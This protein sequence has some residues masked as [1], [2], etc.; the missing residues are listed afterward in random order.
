MS[1]TAADK[2]E[3]LKKYQRDPKDT[4]SPEAQVALTTLRIN[5]LTE[6][7]KTHKHDNESRRGLMRLVSQRRKLLTYLQR[8]DGKAYRKLIADLDLRR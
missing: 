8:V 4:G 5:S 1:F 2:A 6:H 3:V 7:F